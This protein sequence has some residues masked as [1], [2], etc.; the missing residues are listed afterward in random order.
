MNIMNQTGIVRLFLTVLIYF[1]PNSLQAESSSIRI[2]CIG[3]SITYGFGLINREN[4][5]P[6]QLQQELPPYWEVRNFGITGACAS[7]GQKDSYDKTG[8]LEKIGSWQPD[9]I[10][11]MMGS[12]DSK[13]AYWQNRELYIRGCNNLIESI[14]TKDSRVVILLPIPAGINF[15]GIRN[16]IIEEDIKPSLLH[17]AES[18]NYPVL[19]FS[20]DMV[21]QAFLYLDNVHPNK[22]GYSIISRTIRNFLEKFY[23]EK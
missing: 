2:A 4:S 9:I 21:N 15:F 7:S 1:M 3:D 14:K 18:H 22:R 10:L 8:M 11:F 12:N 23:S 16:E 13:E 17:Y 6:S 5:Y 19:D 20:K